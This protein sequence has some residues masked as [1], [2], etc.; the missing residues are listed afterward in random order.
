M[1]FGNLMEV[2][3]VR[4][5]EEVIYSLLDFLGHPSSD[6]VSSEEEMIECLNKIDKIIEERKNY[7]VII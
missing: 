5:C 4:S 2:Q 6:F 7:A 3:C 1:Y